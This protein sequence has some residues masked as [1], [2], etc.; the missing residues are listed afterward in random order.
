MPTINLVQASA[1]MADKVHLMSAVVGGNDVA[2]TGL[3]GGGVS[4][5]CTNPL[6]NIR[7][8]TDV[9]ITYDASV[10]QQHEEIQVSTVHG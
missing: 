8:A 4:F 6:A 3:G 1:H 2:L 7:N 5:T 10:P 9:K